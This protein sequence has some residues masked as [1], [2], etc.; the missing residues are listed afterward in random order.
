[1]EDAETPDTTSGGN[2]ERPSDAPAD[3]KGCEGVT[4]VIITDN[5]AH[6][7]LMALSVSQHLIGVDADIHLVTGE[8]LRDTLAET[9]AAH[10]PHI[11]TERIILM[12]D[13]MI[14]LNPVMLADVAVVKATMAGGHCCFST[15]TPVLMHKSALQVF[16]DTLAKEQLLHT[17][18]AD[19]YFRGTL[20]EGFRPLQIDDWKT[21]P[22]LLPVVS[23][24]PNIEA[25]RK[26]ASWK[27]FM[28]V[29]PDSWSDDLV[30]F[31]EERFP[32]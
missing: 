10:M 26:F 11:E 29:G 5:E 32:E 31:L 22:W 14:L 12:T 17:D 13:G 3:G 2:V 20:P 23:K 18:V 24:N 27:K 28:H 1:M 9:L 7:R 15:A 19:A 8:Q 6:G 21:D 30:K 4:V 25:V 16:L